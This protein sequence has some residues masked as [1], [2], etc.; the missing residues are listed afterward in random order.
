MSLMSGRGRGVWQ[1]HWM[2]V[3]SVSHTPYQGL[4][5][6]YLCICPLQIANAR[7]YYIGAFQIQLFGLSG[8]GMIV[9]M[10][11]LASQPL[12]MHGN[13]ALSKW[14]RIWEYRGIL[15][16]VCAVG[17][18]IH[19]GHPFGHSLRKAHDKWAASSFGV[20]CTAP[21]MHVLFLLY[22]KAMGPL[23]T[24]KT[25]LYSLAV[26]AMYLSLSTHISFSIS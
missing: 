9:V 19:S 23:V 26:T 11:S 15:L 1:S 8:P 2:D 7:S 13:A 22:I 24:A 18:H 4:G 6:M 21:G 3:L 14:H 5:L 25:M 20:H 12:W 10:R 16:P 17:L